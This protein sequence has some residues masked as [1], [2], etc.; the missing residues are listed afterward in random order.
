MKRRSLFSSIFNKDL[1][2]KQWLFLIAL[3]ALTALGTGYL[4]IQ[5]NILR[6]YRDSNEIS[7]IIYCITPTYFR[8]VEMAELTRL[9]HIFLLVPNL[10]WVIVEDAY[11]TN[12]LLQNFLDDL[13][14]ANRSILLH[15]RTPIQFRLRANVSNIQNFPFKFYLQLFFCLVG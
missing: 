7:T 11:Q 9:S 4:V 8:N 10:F 1:T 12:Q 13:G 6:F 2:I 5:R 3:G 15:A 14:L